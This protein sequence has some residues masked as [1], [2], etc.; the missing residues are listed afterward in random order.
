M[1]AGLRDPVRRDGRA[2]RVH[3]VRFLLRKCSSLS[4]AVCVQLPLEF[5]AFA[6]GQ[7]HRIDAEIRVSAEQ[8]LCKTV[9]VRRAQS[10]CL[11]SQLREVDWVDSRLRLPAVSAADRVRHRMGR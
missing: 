5:H 1:V 2:A 7:L 11:S 3:P 8:R 6:D 9:S 10:I 4:L